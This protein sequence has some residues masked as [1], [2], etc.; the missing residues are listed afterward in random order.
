[1]RIVDSGHSDEETTI[2][3]SSKALGRKKNVDSE[4]KYRFFEQLGRRKDDN[5]FFQGTRA[6]EER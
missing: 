4:K 2:T 3:R 5:P 6:E 1:M